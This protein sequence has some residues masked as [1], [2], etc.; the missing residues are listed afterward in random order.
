M[1][2]IKK[3]HVAGVFALGLAGAAS[4]ASAEVPTYR[5]PTAVVEESTT[6][7]APLNVI[8]TAAK[9]ETCKT[10]STA[11][12]AA[13]LVEKLKGKG[14]FTVLAPNDKAFAKL[15]K[16][17]LDSLL[18]PENKAKLAAILAYHVIPGNVSAAEIV[19][20][21]SAKTVNGAM[22]AVTSKDGTVMVNQA[23]VIKADVKCLNGTIHMIDAVL[24]PKE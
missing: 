8:D 16:E 20:L 19:K 14:P 24:M 21:R 11:I 22:V 13:G 18:K 9:D 15:P 7:N 2:C 23:K 10:L 12:K 5:S 3:R 17:T 4:L 6:K 1:L